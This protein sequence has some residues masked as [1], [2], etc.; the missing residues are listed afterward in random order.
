MRT[1]PSARRVVS[2]YLVAKAAGDVGWIR[3]EKSGE[4]FWGREG[5]GVLIIAE[6]GRVL[7]LKRSSSV[8]QPGTWGIP[9]GALQEGE[10][11]PWKG[12]MQE[13]REETGLSVSGKKLGKY[14]FKSGAFRFTT[15]II[16]VDVDAADRMRPRLD[17]ENTDWGWFDAQTIKSIPLHFGVQNILKSW[18]G[19]QAQSVR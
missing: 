12:A 17:W 11:D 3:D 2:A 19:K 5:A 15:F 14:V 4:T 9:G 7:L 6:D 18:V 13:L 8:D 1:I 10:T 16:Q